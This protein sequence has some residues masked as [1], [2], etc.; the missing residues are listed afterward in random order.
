MLCSAIS[1]RQNRARKN[2]H[3]GVFHTVNYDTRVVYTA[4]VVVARR[5]LTV[6]FSTDT[7]QV[8]ASTML[9]HVIYETW[10]PPTAY[11][12]FFSFFFTCTRA[13][14]LIL[15]LQT[16]PRPCSAPNPTCTPAIYNHTPC[17]A[18]IMPA[19]LTGRKNARS[20]FF[21]SITHQDDQT[22]GQKTEGPKNQQL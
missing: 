5:P 6:K 1:S 13:S 10:P 18:Q 11:A 2:Y 9:C 3:L 20:F 8:E 17:S 19:S 14:V 7:A 15:K 12:V 4:G 16:H 21:F 22:R